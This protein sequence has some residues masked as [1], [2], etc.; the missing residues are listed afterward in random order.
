MIVVVRLPQLEEPIQ[1]EME[2]RERAWIKQGQIVP[3]YPP[4][5]IKMFIVARAELVCRECITGAIGQAV[6]LKAKH[7]AAAG[8]KRPG[9]VLN[10]EC[11]DTV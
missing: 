5:A 9:Q 7:T 1:L 8:G 11:W 3:P 4:R 6:Y 2:S 10:P